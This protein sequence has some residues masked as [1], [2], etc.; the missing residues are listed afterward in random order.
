MS[1]HGQ[2]DQMP[3]SSSSFVSPFLSF[4]STLKI[5][6]LQSEN[7]YDIHNGHGHG[8]SNNGNDWIEPT[9]PGQGWTE[10]TEPGLTERTTTTT[11]VAPLPPII[12]NVVSGTNTNKYFTI[13]C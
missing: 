8:H 2:R 6:K 12:V 9:E 3:S 7:D 5:L 4:L 13:F 10:P 1:R 11:T